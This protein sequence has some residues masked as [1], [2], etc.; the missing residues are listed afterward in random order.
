MHHCLALS[1]EYAADRGY[2]A[3]LQRRT[4]PSF[5]ANLGKEDLPEAELFLSRQDEVTLFTE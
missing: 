2:S 5:F 4:H 1:L 3:G